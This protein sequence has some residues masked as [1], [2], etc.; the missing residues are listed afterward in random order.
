[1]LNVDRAP[2]RRRLLATSLFVTLLAFISSACITV[3]GDSGRTTLPS[4]ASV[5][6]GT[7]PTMALLAT[8]TPLPTPAPTPEPVAA[9]VVAFMPYWLIGDAAQT[10]DTDLVTIAAFHSI[11]ASGDGRLVKKKPSGDVPPGWQTLEGDAFAGMKSS[12]QDAG[13]KVVP[14]IA[15]QG[16]TAGTRDRTVTLLSKKKSRQALAGRIAAFVSDGGFDGVNLDFE[17]LPAS[18]SENYTDFVREVRAAL[19]AVDP[20]LHLSID[21]VS[22]LENY[23]LAALT[24]DDA[25]DLAVIMGYGYRT[26]ASAVAGSTAPLTDA[27]PGDLTRSVEAAVAQAAPG[28]LVLGL[29]WYGLAWSTQTDEPGSPVRS[30]EGIDG[31]TQATYGQA[32]DIAAGSGRLYDAAQAS[33]WTAYAS[34][35]CASCSPTW[36]QLWYD[37]PDSFGAK[38]NL[39]LEQGLAG[40]GIWAAGMEGGREEMWWALRDRLRPRID[41][42]PP[43]GSPALDPDALDRGEVDGRSIVVG[44]APL[45]LLGAGD[46]PGGSGLALARVGLTDEVDADGML[47]TGRTYPAVDRIDFPLG[48]ASTGGSAADGP[49]SI[50]VQWRDL[51]GNWSVPVVIDAYVLDPSRCRRPPTSSATRS[52]RPSRRACAAPGSG[53]GRTNAVACVPRRTGLVA[54][55]RPS[56][57]G[58]R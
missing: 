42:T 35:Q 13:V 37:D 7:S 57:H 41:E 28:S 1:M 5:T 2:I 47:V 44:S 38:V 29:P 33:A 21:V 26:N 12:L 40:V 10:L 32:V 11:E 39:A 51:A 19:D 8:P 43:F 3:E 54:G 36:R 52:R 46:D 56:E 14:V 16:W 18:V 17:P 20:E 23:D 58:V 49:R 6:P 45:R 4:A 53:T 31:S 22:G 25:A 24:A 9:E 55:R 48:D 27:G 15:R 50:H 30:G 34:R